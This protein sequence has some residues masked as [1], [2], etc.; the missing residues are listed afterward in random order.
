MILI[1]FVGSWNSLEMTKAPFFLI[2]IS[3][4]ES[5]HFSWCVPEIFILPDVSDLESILSCFDLEY[6]NNDD[7]IR[8]FAE[9]FSLLWLWCLDRQNSVYSRERQTADILINILMKIHLNSSLVSQNYVLNWFQCQFTRTAICQSIF[10]KVSRS[11]WMLLMMIYLRIA[12]KLTH[13]LMY[14]FE[15]LSNGHTRNYLLN[16]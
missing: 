5:F 7:M 13:F 14:F 9:S 1:L 8:S 10:R 2:S 16:W 6:I 15:S 11:M 4:A 3:L 12:M